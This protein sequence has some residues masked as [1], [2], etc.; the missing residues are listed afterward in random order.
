VQVVWPCLCI[1]HNQTG[2]L[3]N[4]CMESRVYEISE[5]VSNGIRDKAEKIFS[6][7]SNVPLITDR[8]QPS[9]QGW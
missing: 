2:E 8:S 6:Y 7:P 9:L 1:V 5:K 3:F 4:A